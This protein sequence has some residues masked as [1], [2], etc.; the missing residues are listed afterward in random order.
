MIARGFLERLIEIVP[1]KIQTILTS[2]GTQFAKREGTKLLIY[3][4]TA[5]RLSCFAAKEAIDFYLESNG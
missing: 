4:T 2:D 1:Y 5:W 3:S